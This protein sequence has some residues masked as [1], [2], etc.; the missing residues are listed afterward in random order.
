MFDETTMKCNHAG[1]KNKVVGKTRGEA[2]TKARTAGWQMKS[3]TEHYCPDHKT[4]SAVVAKSTTKA[5]KAA[6][7]NKKAAKG[8]TLKATKKAGGVISYS[9]IA[10]Q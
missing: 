2:A 3:S 8:K 10:E 6:K 7:N 1:C 5:A 4:T 9:P